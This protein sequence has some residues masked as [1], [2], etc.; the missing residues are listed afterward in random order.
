MDYFFAVLIL[1]ALDELGILLNVDVIQNNALD[2]IVGRSMTFYDTLKPN[3][4][5]FR[6][7]K[8]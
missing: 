6:L 3:I 4:Q 1:S 7:Q 8:N 2:C 5:L